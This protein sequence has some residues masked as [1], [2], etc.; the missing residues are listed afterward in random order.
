VGSGR[1][2][3]TT[4]SQAGGHILPATELARGV[5][6]S[7]GW[8]ILVA[9]ASLAGLAGLLIARLGRG[10]L[11]HRPI[12]N[13]LAA[14]VL[15]GLLVALVQ[16]LTAGATLLLA[17]LIPGSESAE[18]RSLAASLGPVV[19]QNVI[20]AL[21]IS[22]YLL[23]LMRQRARAKSGGSEPRAAPVFALALGVYA[24]SDGM[25]TA[26]S[27]LSLTSGLTLELLGGVALAHICRGLAAAGAFAARG[28][29]FGWLGSAVLLG[30]PLGLLGMSMGRQLGVE[31]ANTVAVPLLASGVAL[32]V[33]SIAT[34]LGPG[35]GN[36]LRRLPVGAFVAGLGLALAAARL[37][38]SSLA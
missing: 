25:A 16:R 27:S 18:L 21:V 24:L 10:R 29:G 26:S 9:L 36:S 12:V 32:L 23:C 5:A 38:G 33:V 22:V 15:V 13:A 7:N 28:D 31:L 3:R 19:I 34:I 37:T 35:L 2:K 6:Q 8:L 4:V 20:A 30:G 1:S 11:S 14:G 17:R